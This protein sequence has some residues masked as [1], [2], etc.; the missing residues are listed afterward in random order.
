M[1]RTQEMCQVLAPGDDDEGRLRN[2]ELVGGGGSASCEWGWPAGT[3]V[4]ASR[5]EYR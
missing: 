5:R 4:F 1:S 3:V 2:V